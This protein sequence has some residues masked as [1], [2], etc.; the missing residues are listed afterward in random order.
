[1]E[2]LSTRKVL[3]RAA[4]RLYSYLRVRFI[5][6]C[7]VPL[8]WRDFPEMSNNDCGVSPVPPLPLSDSVETVE[9]AIK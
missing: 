5:G 9:K 2:E 4:E 1:M 8:L 7:F 6:M 3:A